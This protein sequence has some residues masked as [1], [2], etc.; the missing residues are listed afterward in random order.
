[1]YELIIHEN[2]NFQWFLC[3]SIYDYLMN[4]L[5]IIEWNF[6]NFSFTEDILS[7]IVRAVKR[8]QLNIIVEEYLL[9]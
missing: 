7:T 3:G 5:F 1:M 6:E 2:P 4:I 9:Q 8:T